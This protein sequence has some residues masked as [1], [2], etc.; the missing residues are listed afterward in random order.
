MPGHRR[1]RRFRFPSGSDGSVLAG[2]F[3]R[4]GKAEFVTGMDDVG[5]RYA[6]PPR[7]LAMVQAVVPGDGVKGVALLNLVET[8]GIGTISETAVRHRRVGRSRAP[9]EH[10]GQN[11]RNRDHRA[12]PFHAGTPVQAAGNPCAYPDPVTARRPNPADASPTK[13]LSRRP[14]PPL[15]IPPLPSQGGRCNAQDTVLSW[16]PPRKQAR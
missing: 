13:R 1:F 6:V 8:R 10:R 9:G 15:S 4:W 2:A 3:R 16:V 11:H 5:R 7:Q 14:I 12:R